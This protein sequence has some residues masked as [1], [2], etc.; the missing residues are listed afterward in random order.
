[1]FVTIDNLVNFAKVITKI[2]LFLKKINNL[3]GINNVR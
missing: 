2:K 1:M 3:L